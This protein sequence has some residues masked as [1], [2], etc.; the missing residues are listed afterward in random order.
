MNCPPERGS[1]GDGWLFRIHYSAGTARSVPEHGSLPDRSRLHVAP[2]KSTF[3]FRPFREGRSPGTLT[4]AEKGG[5]EGSEGRRL[6]EEVFTATGPPGVHA[7]PEV[8]IFSGIA[9]GP[10][11]RVTEAYEPVLHPFTPSRLWVAPAG[12]AALLKARGWG[13][14]I[15]SCSQAATGFRA[16]PSGFACP[17]RIRAAFARRG[18][19]R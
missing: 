12:P 3:S 16:D 8:S 6:R 2:G 19:L 9:S 1:P 17:G 11:A 13:S 14:I 5:P 18:R 7:S 10:G 4:C 15:R